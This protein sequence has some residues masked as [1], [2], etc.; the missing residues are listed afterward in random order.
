MMKWIAKCL[1]PLLTWLVLL[2]ASPVSA[3]VLNA[4]Q[5]V[6]DPGIPEIGNW[7][8]VWTGEKF[9]VT[10]FYENPFWH[11]R[12]FPDAFDIWW[13]GA[14]GSAQ[15]LRFERSRDFSLTS[16]DFY[17]G[18]DTDFEEWNC[19]NP[20]ELRSSKGG[21][22]FLEPDAGETTCYLD[23]GGIVPWPWLRGGGNL[24][25]DGPL[26]ES[27]D[28]FTIGWV[29]VGAPLWPD[30]TRAQVQVNYVP[31]P[32]ATMLLLSAVGIAAMKAVRRRAN[33][34]VKRRRRKK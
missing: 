32:S 16:I 4:E 28:W 2:S 11:Q 27:I 12:G 31:E 15:G 20:M 25:L 3:D 7:C 34:P 30:F 33:P 9:T 14:E 26:W 29:G 1:A 13:G 10:E 22:A 5:G 19:A 8:S 6:C 23:R 18:Y 21:Y 17:L 24:V